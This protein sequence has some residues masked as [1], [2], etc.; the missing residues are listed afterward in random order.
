MGIVGKITKAYVR[1][2]NTA[3]IVC[4][5]CGVPKVVNLSQLK[6]KRHDIKMKCRCNTVFGVQLDHRH[7][8]R[9]QTNL[10][11]TYTILRDGTGG[12]VIHI[13]DISR[14]GLG[15]TV[16]GIHNLKEKQ[17]IGVEFQLN[18]RN[19]TTIRKRAEVRIVN[20][21]KIGC[22]F[23]EID[24]TGSTIGKALGFY[25]QKTTSK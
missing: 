18:D 7:H 10:P 5:A 8:Y 19:M 23:A 13:Q 22:K 9:K 2:N 15:F 4:P 6:T 12:G 1:S 14:G 11:G 3:T 24:D 21:N 20:K 17:I 25:L 16:S